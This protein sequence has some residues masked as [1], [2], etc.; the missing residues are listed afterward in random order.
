VRSST[1][2]VALTFDDAPHRATT[3]ALVDLLDRYRARATFFLIGVNASR[4]EDLVRRIVDSG[5]ELGNHLLSD[6]PSILLS[7]TEFQAQLLRSRCYS[8]S[9]RNRSILSAEARVLH[10]ENAEDSCRKQ[11]PMC[12]RDNIHT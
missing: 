11:L 12:V 8:P 10:P 3:P 2:V 7:T 5:H 4:H 1:R 9:F 6:Y